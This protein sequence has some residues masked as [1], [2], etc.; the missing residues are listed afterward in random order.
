MDGIHLDYIRFTYRD[1]DDSRTYP[2]D[3]RSL[4]LFALDTGDRESPAALE[5]W[6]RACVTELVLG[7]SAA[8][9]SIPR[10]RV[11]LTAAVFTP[12]I[13]IGAAIGLWMHHRVPERPFAMALY[14]AS[15][16]AGARLLLR[17]LGA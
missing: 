3:R 1:Y 6:M 4:D 8:V 10:R 17:G 2:E 13:P 9:R 16:V 12:L 7:V 5:G 15:A 11:L 14:V